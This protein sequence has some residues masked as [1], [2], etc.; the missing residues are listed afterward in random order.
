MGGDK[1]YWVRKATKSPDRTLHKDVL[2]NLIGMLS[3]ELNITRKSKQKETKRNILYNS[4][5]LHDL[6]MGV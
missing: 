5:I 1:K 6:I 2:D 4:V 3:L